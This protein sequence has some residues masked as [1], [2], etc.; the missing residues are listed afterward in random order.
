MFKGHYRVEKIKQIYLKKYVSYI[1]PLLIFKFDDYE[2]LFLKN[3]QIVYLG[4]RNIL[5]R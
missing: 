1:N 5:S 4:E 3:Y 2:F